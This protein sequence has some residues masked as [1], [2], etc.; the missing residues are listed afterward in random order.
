V[1][2]GLSAD[3]DGDSA[4][5]ELEFIINGEYK[6]LHISKCPHKK[7]G[8]VMK[9]NKEIY[10]VPKGIKVFGFDPKKEYVTLCD[11]THFSVHHNL[12]MVKVKTQSGRETKVSRDHS[13]FG[14]IPSTQELGRF[15]AEDGIGWA[16][17]RPRYLYTPKQL[18]S[19]KLK[20]K[21]LVSS[22]KLTEDFGWLVGV[23]AGDGWVSNNFQLSETPI[24]VGLANIDSIIQ[25]KFKR[26]VW[27]IMPNI[28][29]KEYEN[30]HEFE[31]T[32]CHSK[33]T[34][35][36][37]RVFARLFNEL[38]ES[39]RGA[40]NKKLPSYFVQGK[41]PFLLGLFGGLIDTDG[42]V[43]I[44]K[45]KAKNKPQFMAHY[46]TKSDCLADHIGVLAT[47]LGIRSNV[48]TYKK[49]NKFYHQITFS[50][51]DLALIASEIPCV[52]PHKRELLDLLNKE[53]FDS[54]APE[55]ARWDMVPIPTDVA[56]NLWNLCSGARGH[57]LKN[58]SKEQERARRKNS[59]IYTTL[60]KAIKSERISRAFLNE[61][62]DYFGISTLDKVGGSWFNLV[63]NE[64][65]IWDFIKEVTL[66]PGRHTAWDLTVPNGNTFMTSNQ[67]IVYD[68]LM[69]HTPIGPKAIEEAKGMT[70]SKLLFG[71]K[72][73][74]NLLVFPQMEAIMGISHAAEVDDKN[75]PK[76][77]KTKADAMKDYNSGKI[78]L[79]TRVVIQEKSGN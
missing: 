10:E 47:M 35:V 69:I 48:H 53:K 26:I 68:T 79:G 13:M 54:T 7:K 45:A 51:P 75:K 29:I 38:I 37:S 12:E 46:T 60:Y 24:H 44:V 9:G 14:F 32:I 56:K 67:L 4:D 22:I 6:R 59:C 27:G 23:W 71:D 34:H 20:N 78:S 40:E 77:Y 15:R 72:N 33:K 61:L 16:I 49:N 76:I 28:S 66:L 30:I 52:H 50:I 11:V 2:E 5:S 19:V 70:V 17:P 65:I 74:E 8:V 39:C 73:R 21:E 63:I 55:N 43:S 58:I 3:Y 36:N 41:R 57:I 1:E 18:S 42:T 62:I 64:N 25:N 31:G